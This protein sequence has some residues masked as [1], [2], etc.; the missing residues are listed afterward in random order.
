MYLTGCLPYS[1]FYPNISFSTTI[2]KVDLSLAFNKR[3][4]RPNFSQ[5]NGNVI[6]VNRFLFQKGN[7]Y[8]NKHN[9]YDVN[10]QAILKP[11]YLNIG[12]AYTENPVSLFFE[13]QANNALLLTYANFPKMQDLNATLNFNHQIAFWQPNYTIGA[14]PD[15]DTSKIKISN[16]PIYGYL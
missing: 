14:A 12:Y 4:S 3:T 9:I 7:P 8:L 2:K 10:L 15:F 11:F 6:Y 16:Y 1:D 13:E 5:L